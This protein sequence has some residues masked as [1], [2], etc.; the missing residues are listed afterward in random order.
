MT[1]FIWL[2]FFS[3]NET[4]PFRKFIFSAN[5]VPKMVGKRIEK[6]SF[7]L[8]STGFIRL[9]LIIPYG[10]SSTTYKLSLTGGDIK[11]VQGDTGHATADMVVNR[12]SHIQDKSRIKII[13]MLEKDFYDTD[14]TSEN[15]EIDDIMNA[16]QNDSELRELII[17]RISTNSKWLH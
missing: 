4:S 5:I 1:L 16:L 9:V 2:Y 11:S 6:T 17:A 7:A 12:Y 13:E 10:H 15:I 14:D 3:L 8:I